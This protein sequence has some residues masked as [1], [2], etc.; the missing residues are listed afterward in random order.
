MLLPCICLWPLF[1]V[2]I[3]QHIN[4]GGGGT[5]DNPTIEKLQRVENAM[6][7]SLVAFKE[8]ELQ[9]LAKLKSQFRTLLSRK[10][11][12]GLHHPRIVA[13]VTGT[14]LAG[15][16]KCVESVYEYTPRSRILSVVA[17]FDGVKENEAWRNTLKARDE[18]VRSHFYL[19]V[20][21][22]RPAESTLHVIFD[23]VGKGVNAARR[24]GAEFA[25][26][27]A[28][29]LEEVGMKDP[30]E[31]IL[32]LLLRE[33]ASLSSFEW[34]DA[35]TA[36]LVMDGRQVANAVSFAVDYYDIAGSGK[37]VR[38]APG[39]RPGFDLALVPHW[40]VDEDVANGGDGKWDS[41][42]SP[43]LAGA[44][45]ALRLNTFLSLPVV[46]TGLKTHYASNLELA[47]N[48]WM[49]GD[50]ID[51]LPRARAIVDP[52]LLDPVDSHISNEYVARLAGSWMD[53][54]YALEVWKQ[55]RKDDKELVREK[56]VQ[57][58]EEV[59][60]TGVSDARE[61]CRSFSWYA[62]N[63]N[64][65]LKM[66]K[67]GVVKLTPKKE[68]EASTK[69]KNKKN[70]NKELNMKKKGVVKLTPKKGANNKDEPTQKLR[71]TKKKKQKQVQKEEMKY[72][73]KMPEPRAPAKL[74]HGRLL[75]AEQLEILS[76]A[77]PI[78]LAYED[79]SNGHTEH[80]HK[81]AT[82][83]FGTPGYV[84]DATALRDH[85]PAFDFGGLKKQ[86]CSQRDSHYRMLSNRVKIDFEGHE[87]KGDEGRAKIFCIVYTIE[88]NH[89]RL[90][91][92]LQ[93][94]GPKCDG[95]MVASTK[96][97]RSL[98]TVNIVHQGPEE[99]N[100]I[101]QK[102]RSIWSYVYDNY[103]EDYDWFH[104]GGD[105]LFLLVE[106]MRLYLESNE[107]K[108]AAKGGS[109]DGTPPGHE[110]PLFLGRRFAEG[111]NRNRMFNSGGAG[112]SIN[113]AAIKALVDKFPTCF[114]NAHTFA[115]DV[116]VAACFRQMGVLPFE[117][118]DQNGSERYMP[119][120]PGHH[121]TYQPPEENPQ[122]DW[123]VKYSPNGIK[124]GYE[125]CSEHSVAFHYIKD[126]L[127]KRM[128]ATLYHLCD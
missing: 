124:T 17:V 98:H 79:Y 114:P 15:V 60:S 13:V 77:S 125:H 104:I 81:G 70:V 111:G 68:A 31:E 62:E 56:M 32:L 122:D 24:T 119:F 61:G 90:S 99:Y 71:I 51:I 91:P 2:F 33:D 64:K 101:W 107:I 20:K 42:A 105:D 123:Y 112:Y 6:D 12:Y 87:A 96:T 57:W 128:Y 43:A 41:Y 84:H 47:F 102:V 8:K 19:G 11:G 69:T 48:L 28:T 74:T 10:G 5:S 116:M 65:E 25:S 38:S 1:F 59:L 63:V 30:R 94:W 115:E 23:E 26:V 85:P 75:N 36:A 93:T 45:T 35:V 92:I 9:N 29:K 4:D 22:L 120:A 44:A 52:S 126:N 21:R 46:D 40:R 73:P 97:D 106:N 7:R 3:L 37:V 86:M 78:D 80:P 108:L 16:T 66:K 58:S 110:K 54:D 76:H 49:C 113:K 34:L 14:S 55:R 27:Y 82:D 67:K 39:S 53:E 72:K 103:Y 117:T 18:K 121:L 83:E 118:K 89:N 100:N 109:T 88:E 95:F 127:M 50:G